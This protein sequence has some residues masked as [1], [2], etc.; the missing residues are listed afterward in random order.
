MLVSDSIRQ[1]R[2]H[3][4]HVR[5]TL[6]S[7]SGSIDSADTTVILSL[8]DP[9]PTAG[10]I[11]EVRADNTSEE[12]YVWSL[13]GTD[14]VVERGWGDSSATAFNSGALVAINPT[15]TDADIFN[16]IIQEVRSLPSEGLYRIDSE[17]LEYN[18]TTDGF[19]TTE[20][21]NMVGPLSLQYTIGGR[22][23]WTDKFTDHSGLLRPWNMALPDNQ[24]ATLFYRG[25]FIQPESYDQDLAEYCQIP[26][27]AQDIVA[28][29]A[30]IRMV[31]GRE[32]L[33]GQVAAQAHARSNEDV[34]SG[35]GARSVALLE[36]WKANR[37]AVENQRLRETHPRRRT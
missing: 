5:E 37:L 14:M 16:E 20:I 1:V 2:Q 32:Q 33:R 24:T 35:S 19:N 36:R 21:D 25:G 15:L 13:L 29:G 3:L 22:T 6:N 18:Y 31:Y 12:M 4:G 10:T 26:E 34:Q 28:I 30:A 7:L 23:F 27:S 8:E 9:V 17:E 11:V